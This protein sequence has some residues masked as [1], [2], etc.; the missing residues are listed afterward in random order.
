MDI[1]SLLQQIADRLQP[2][3]DT[4]LL[5]AQVLIAHVLEKPRSWVV[6]HLDATLSKAQQQ[7]LEEAVRRLEQREPLPYILG[8]WEFCGLDFVVTRDV[9]IPRPETELMVEHAVSW[10]RSRPRSPLSSLRMADVGTGSG[11][12]AVALAK[13]IPDVRVLATDISLPALKVARQNAI[14]HSVASRIDFVQCD[15]LPPHAESL[16]TDSHF[17]VICANLPY[18]PTHKLPELRTYGHEP[19]LALNG[20]EDGLDLIRRLL[21]VA[22]DWLTL[23][24]LLLIEIEAGQGLAALSLAY[25][26]FDHATIQLRR[27]LAGRDRLLIIRLHG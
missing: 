9:L 15:L 21:P 2:V 12:I 16:P 27:D 4:P 8:H 6:A 14:R 10:L 13:Q 25:D 18:I 26:S 3:T 22:A 7:A 5:D 23:N 17:H 11:C 20:G 1:A 24:G 19:E